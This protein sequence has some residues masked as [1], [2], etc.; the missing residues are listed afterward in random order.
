M[1]SAIHQHVNFK[2]LK[3]RKKISGTCWKSVEGIMTYHQSPS[4]KN[5]PS[6][7]RQSVCDWRTS[8]LLSCQLLLMSASYQEETSGCC[9]RKKW[10]VRV[11]VNIPKQIVLYF[12]Y[13]AGF[14][15]KSVSFTACTSLFSP[16]FSK[17]EI[18]SYMTAL[19]LTQFWIGY[20]NR[21]DIS[22]ER[23]PTSDN[24]EQILEQPTEL[25]MRQKHV[26]KMVSSLW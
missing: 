12:P 21:Y 9:S 3:K 8:W 19:L 2:D 20:I 24:Y 22:H 16:A 7:F 5:V 18:H 6:Q 15:R 1:L 23:E 4:A 25:K 14:F 17:E 13:S 11:T 10:P 26:N